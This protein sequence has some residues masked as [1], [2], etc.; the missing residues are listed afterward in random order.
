M[1]YKL[2]KELPFLSKD[3]VFGT[4]T[5][6]GGGFGVDR[7]NDKNGAHNGVTVF[8]DVENYTLEKIIE[9]RE[10]IEKI[11]T[12]NYELLELFKSGYINDDYILKYIKL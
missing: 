11:P 7:G 4:G 6:V 10:W 9:N 3:T 12:S 2:L 5:W 1:K 8:N